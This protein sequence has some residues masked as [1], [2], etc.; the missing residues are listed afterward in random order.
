MRIENNF[1]SMLKLIKTLK[2]KQRTIWSN[3]SGQIE[4]NL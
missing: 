2:S 4:D 3:E 1:L